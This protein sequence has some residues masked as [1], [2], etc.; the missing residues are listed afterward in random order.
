MN[1]LRLS[2]YLVKAKT[3][4]SLQN[5]G[6]EDRQ[7]GSRGSSQQSTSAV[8]IRWR[9]IRIGSD[10]KTDILVEICRGSE[11]KEYLVDEGEKRRPWEKGERSTVV[12]LRPHGQPSITQPSTTAVTH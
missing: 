2:R 4:G 3:N 11:Q 12:P 5:D 1:E 9:P 6:R 10:R 7:R 8:E